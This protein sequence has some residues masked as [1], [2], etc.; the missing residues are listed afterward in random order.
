MDIDNDEVL[1]EQYRYSPEPLLT[2]EDRE[3]VLSQGYEI[4][5]AFGQNINQWIVL[6]KPGLEEINIF[7]G[8]GGVGVCHFIGDMLCND[9]RHAVKENQHI[10]NRRR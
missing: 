8:P 4:H 5:P 2:P 10:P 6:R 1:A 9:L 3:W 7:Y